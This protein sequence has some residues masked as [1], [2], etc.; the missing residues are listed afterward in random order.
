MFDI[1]S[2][3]QDYFFIHTNYKF[4]ANHMS[5]WACLKKK[6]YCIII[7]IKIRVFIVTST[8]LTD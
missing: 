1:I 3:G 2:G 8:Y 6:N 7:T 4:V 5:I